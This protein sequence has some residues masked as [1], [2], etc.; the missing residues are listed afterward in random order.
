MSLTPSTRSMSILAIVGLLPTVLI[1]VD[2]SL[3]V[4]Q[5]DVEIE[6]IG[7]INQME[8]VAREIHYHADQLGSHS[9][10]RQTTRWTHLHHLMQIKPLV[11]DGLNP[12]LRRLIE[13]QSRLPGWHQDTIDQL[14]ASARTLAT[15]ATSAILNQNEA[16]TLSIALN[17]EYKELITRINKHSD[18]LVRTADAAG[19]YAAAQRQAVEAGL[20]VP[21][22]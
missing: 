3:T 13:I 22:H 18:A 9:R 11:N 5:P 7:L 21:K 12:A 17:D 1:A 4:K 19:D 6:G 8:D 20:N 14:L 10:S 16:S 2:L 15:D